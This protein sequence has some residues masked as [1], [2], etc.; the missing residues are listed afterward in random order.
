MFKVVNCDLAVIAFVG[1]SGELN[2]YV[3][4]NRCGTVERFSAVQGYPSGSLPA[5]LA[6]NQA[7]RAVVIWL[8]LL[9]L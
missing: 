6:V 2:G 1:T 7:V 8:N 5:N 3:L 9:L 4:P